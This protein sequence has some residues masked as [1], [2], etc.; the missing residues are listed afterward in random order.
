MDQRELEELDEQLGVLRLAAEETRTTF[1]D[2]LWTRFLE[3]MEELRDNVQEVLQEATRIVGPTVE[4]EKAASEGMGLTDVL[5]EAK[6]SEMFSLP[7]HSPGAHALF[8]GRYLRWMCDGRR[9][10]ASRLT[11]TGWRRVEP[12]EVKERFGDPAAAR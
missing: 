4:K 9:I 7:P 10:Y 2:E 8:D 1:R 6:E 12:A 5:V 3:E 11:A